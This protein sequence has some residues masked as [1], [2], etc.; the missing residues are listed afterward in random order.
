M[1]NN[2]SFTEIEVVI[3]DNYEKKLPVVFVLDTSG[4]MHGNP[5]KELN[6]GIKYFL[7]E[8]LKDEKLSISLD[9]AIVTFDS[10][11]KLVRD[12]NLLTEGNFP[13]LASEGSTKLCDGVCSGINSLET[14]V[15]WYKKTGQMIFRPYLIL[16]TDGYPDSDQNI[17]NLKERIHLGVEKKHFNFWSFGVDG[18]DF[19]MLKK[20]AHINFAPMKLSSSNFVDLFQFLSESFNS[21][22][23][24]QEGDQLQ[25]IPPGTVTVEV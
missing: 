7:D 15:K 21:I 13:T 18:A 1:A 22:S 2:D 9:I 5:I 19:G 25:L 17:E 3:P 23:S 24:S 20:I 10:N 14:H 4:S 6:R 12:F 11:V 8:S 16:I